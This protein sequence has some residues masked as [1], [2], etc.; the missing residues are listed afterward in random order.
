MCRDGRA[1]ALPFL[2]GLAALLLTEEGPGDA[3]EGG[4]DEG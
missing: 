3:E 4:H 1:S 2:F